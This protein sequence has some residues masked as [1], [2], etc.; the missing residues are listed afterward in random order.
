MGAGQQALGDLRF[1][2]GNAGVVQLAA[3]QRQ[4]RRFHLGIG[5]FRA[6][7]HEAHDGFGDF[8]R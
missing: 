3:D 6:A 4:Q 8:L 2:R 1:T 5:D 7:G